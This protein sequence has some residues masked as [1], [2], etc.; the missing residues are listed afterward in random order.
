MTVIHICDIT[1]GCIRMLS[2]LWGI[3]GVRRPR[4]I[5]DVNA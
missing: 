4:E 1:F 2:I 5:K 3:L